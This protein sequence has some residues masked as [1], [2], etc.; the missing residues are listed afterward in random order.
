M[1]IRRSPQRKHPLNHSPVTVESEVAG[2]VTTEYII[3]LI[4]TSGREE[5]Q[6]IAQA[7]LEQRKAACVNI[8]SGVDS[9][10]WWQGKIE[11][12]QECLLVVKSRTAQLDDLVEVVKK[13]HSYKVPEVIALPVIGGNADYL[14]WLGENTK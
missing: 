10:F 9:H 5:A 2:M 13:R 8:I 12:A 6:K 1:L 11:N 4:T 14:D 3:V 7:L